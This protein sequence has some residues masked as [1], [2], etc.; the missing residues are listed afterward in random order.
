MVYFCDTLFYIMMLIFSYGSVWRWIWWFLR[1]DVNSYRKW[2][3]HKVLQRWQFLGSKQQ[4]R[5]E[6]RRIRVLR[7]SLQSHYNECD[8]YRVLWMRQLNVVSVSNTFVTVLDTNS[9]RQSTYML[10]YFCVLG[11]N[12]NINCVQCLVI[13]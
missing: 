7:P 11:V 8:A 9:Q 5:K 13:N 2:S 10:L 1:E 4:R 12:V 3:Q 6:K